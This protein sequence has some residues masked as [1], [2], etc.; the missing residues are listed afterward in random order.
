MNDPNV[1]VG[2]YNSPDKLVKDGA[3]NKGGRSRPFSFFWIS[4]SET[5]IAGETADTGTLPDSAPQ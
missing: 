2:V 4:S 3:G 5:R 1:T